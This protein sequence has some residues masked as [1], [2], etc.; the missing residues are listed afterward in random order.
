MAKANPSLDGKAE[1]L[2]KRTQELLDTMLAA[3]TGTKLADAHTH[4]IAAIDELARH[5]YA[6][7]GSIEPQSAPT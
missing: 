1:K 3:D 4:L 2:L 6:Q 7:I 5:R